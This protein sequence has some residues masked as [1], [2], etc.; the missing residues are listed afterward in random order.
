[1]T[2]KFHK[3]LLL[4]L[5]LLMC[6]NMKGR[7]EDNNVYIFIASNISHAYPLGYKL[8]KDIQTDHEQVNKMV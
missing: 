2:W 5:Q 8:E 7:N 4:A 3:D 6:T 1:M